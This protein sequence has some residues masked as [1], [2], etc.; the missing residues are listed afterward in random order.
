[1]VTLHDL[2]SQLDNLIKTFK[3]LQ[4]E[5]ANYVGSGWNEYV[6]ARKMQSEAITRQIISMFGNGSSSWQENPEGYSMYTQLMSGSIDP[7]SVTN[8][9]EGLLPEPIPELVP[10]IEQPQFTVST[11]EEA[12]RIIEQFKTQGVILTLDDFVI[13]NVLVNYYVLSPSGQVT[14]INTGCIT[15]KVRTLEILPLTSSQVVTFQSQG[16]TVMPVSS[17][18][19]PDQFADSISDP[20]KYNGSI[21]NGVNPKLPCTIDNTTPTYNPPPT[22]II[23]LP[24]TT[25]GD[26]GLPLPLP[27]IGGGFAFIGIGLLFLYLWRRK[28]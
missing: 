28:K 11:I 5:M 13:E 21:I 10:I 24:D 25:D 27:I 20:V 9:R 19:T 12:Y 8:F 1:M 2:Q 15:L 26:Q 4:Y 22:D 17:A 18:G 14:D 16:Y 3:R 23:D 6:T 7:Y